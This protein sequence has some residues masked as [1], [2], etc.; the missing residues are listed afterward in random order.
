MRRGSNHT[1]ED[2]CEM[3]KA[4]VYPEIPGLTILFSTGCAALAGRRIDDGDHLMPIVKDEL[5][6]C[7]GRRLRGCIRARHG[8]HQLPAVVV[9]R[10]W[11]GSEGIGTE[12]WQ[13]DGGENQSQCGF[14]GWV[15]LKCRTGSAGRWTGKRNNTALRA[16]P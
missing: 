11:I 1:S 12:K 14:H 10:L 2:F 6:F 16:T 9:N 5:L 15:V 8:A 3:I 13:D 7:W 4:Q